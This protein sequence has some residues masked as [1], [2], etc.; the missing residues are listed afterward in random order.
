MLHAEPSAD[1]AKAWA[2]NRIARLMS[3][4]AK[5]SWELET[6][7]EQAS[8]PGESLV[9][10][11]PCLGERCQAVNGSGI[12]AH[13]SQIHGWSSN[14]VDASLRLLVQETRRRKASIW[15][16]TRSC[17]KTLVFGTQPACQ[18]MA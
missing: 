13:R 1:V 6:D 5:L 12:A 18:K 4:E 17:A 7:S 3:K 11:A 15:A 8:V 10:N 16:S 2:S 14:R 9:C